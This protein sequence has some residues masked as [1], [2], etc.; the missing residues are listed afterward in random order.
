MHSFNR[1]NREYLES[2]SGAQRLVATYFPFS[3]F[4]SGVA[5]VI[6]LGV[7]AG[8]IRDGRLTAGA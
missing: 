3:Q 2:R 7:G 6:V 1:L 4:L 8:M 5:G